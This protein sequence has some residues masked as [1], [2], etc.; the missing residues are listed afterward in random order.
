MSK[1]MGELVTILGVWGVLLCAIIGFKG[2][3]VVSA[4][5]ALSGSCNKSYFIEVPY[6]I[7][8]NWFCADT[9]Q[10]EGQLK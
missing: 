3:L 10:S 7:S 8:G 1:E 4:I 6:F 5:K 2:S 9:E